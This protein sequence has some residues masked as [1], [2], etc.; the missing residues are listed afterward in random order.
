M[1]KLIFLLGI[2]FFS[3]SAWAQAPTIKVVDVPGVMSSSSTSSNPS[4][5]TE[6]H[7][8]ICKP[9]FT[10]ICIRVT[11][12]TSRSIPSVASDLSGVILAGDQLTVVSDPNGMPTSPV[13]GYLNIYNNQMV[14]GEEILVREHL[15]IINILPTIPVE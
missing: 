5:G 8:T 7:K 15:F 12:N 14:P 13:S 4:A 2:F 3:H 6:T 9:P 10:S 1:K 11:I